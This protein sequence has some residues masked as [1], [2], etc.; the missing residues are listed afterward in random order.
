M[1]QYRFN[2]VV[3]L[4]ILVDILRNLFGH[5]EKEI[6]ILRCGFYCAEAPV[7]ILRQYLC[8]VFFLVVDHSDTRLSEHVVDGLFVRTG[9]LVLIFCHKLKF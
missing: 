4:K 6:F 1:F 3:L 7:G 2:A 5:D 8:L 9:R